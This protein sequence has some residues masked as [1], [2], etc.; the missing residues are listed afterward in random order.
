MSF[1]S[2]VLPTFSFVPVPHVAAAKGLKTIELNPLSNF[3]NYLSF[4]VQE[5]PSL[6]LASS[7]RISFRKITSDRKVD[8]ACRI[9]VAHSQE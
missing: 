9:H 3:V 2:F 6:K 8:T 7:R 1:H 4:Q 5:S